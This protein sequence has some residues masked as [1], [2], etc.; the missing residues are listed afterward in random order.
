[1]SLAENPVKR[2]KPPEEFVVPH[3]QTNCL[4]NSL[5]YKEVL[6]NPRLFYK[7]DEL[8]EEYKCVVIKHCERKMLKLDEI[9]RRQVDESKCR[10]LNPDELHALMRS[11]G[12][13]RRLKHQ[14]LSAEVA[15]V[16][17]EQ[18]S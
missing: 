1:M 12:I 18:Q 13:D 4:T 7:W 5:A 11:S 10:K 16:Y 8:P 14:I 9:E 2:G 15:I 17:S 3:M 6:K